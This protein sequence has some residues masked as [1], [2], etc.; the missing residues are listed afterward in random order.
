MH[1]KYWYQPVRKEL[2]KEAFGFFYLK[3]NVF[4]SIIQQ[5]LNLR[6]VYSTL[7]HLKR[8]FWQ[9]IILKRAKQ[10][11]FNGSNCYQKSKLSKMFTEPYNPGERYISI[12]YLQNRIIHVK[13]IFL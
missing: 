12:K 10:I 3:S 13:G 1:I 11:S 6:F 4:W 8:I 9:K 7:L 2:T 5:S